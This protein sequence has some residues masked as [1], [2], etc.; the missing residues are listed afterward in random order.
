MVGDTI[1]DLGLARSAGLKAAVG[2]LSGVGNREHLEPHADILVYSI[3][4]KTS[5]FS[6]TTSENLLLFSAVRTVIYEYGYL[7]YLNL[8]NKFPM[9]LLNKS[10]LQS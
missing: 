6:W 10:F 7:F 8:D 5:P 4:L 1:A 2:V 3:L 9:T